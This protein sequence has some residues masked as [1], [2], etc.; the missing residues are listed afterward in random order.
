MEV[1]EQKSWALK[2]HS[3]RK[4]AH[5]IAQISSQISN[6]KFTRET[7]Y[8]IQE[9]GLLLR[10]A[11]GEKGLGLKMG[12]TSKAKRE[13]MNLDSPLYGEL[14]DKMQVKNEGIFSLQKSI[15]PKIEPEVAFLMGRELKGTPK[16][17]EALSAISEIYPCLEILDSRYLTFKYFSMEDVI[18]DN[19]SSSHFVLGPAL[20]DFRER[21][22]VLEN[23]QV[24][25]KINDEVSSEG[26]TGLISGDP[27]LS[28]IQLCE[29][30]EKRGRTLPAGNLV[31]AGACTMA[32]S[33]EPQMKISVE[34]QELG[35]AS[36]CI[37]K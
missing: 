15:H 36:V 14:T 29:L 4:K 3:A 35:S 23:L 28:I 24:K 2:L 33:L 31:L 19:S 7:A 27:V 25:M 1:K 12:L 26:N 6:H 5:P 10:K 18:A 22:L 34:V 30:L 8:A 9:Q 16:R 11:E 37:E 17:E 20:T 32:I 13:Q 21:N